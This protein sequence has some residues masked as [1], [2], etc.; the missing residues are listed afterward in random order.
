MT[1]ETFER[2]LHDL[3]NS[4]Q[5]KL[6]K[7]RRYKRNGYIVILPRRVFDSLCDRSGI[8]VKRAPES[9]GPRPGLEGRAGA[10]SKDHFEW[11]PFDGPFGRLLISPHRSS[12]PYL[13]IAW[14]RPKTSFAEWCTAHGVVFESAENRPARRLMELAYDVALFFRHHRRGKGDAR[15]GKAYTVRTPVPPL[16]PLV[17]NHETGRRFQLYIGETY[18]GSPARVHFL[19]VPDGKP[20]PPF[21]VQEPVKRI[22]HQTTRNTRNKDRL[23]ARTED[24]RSRFYLPSDWSRVPESKETEA[25]PKNLQTRIDDLVKMLAPSAD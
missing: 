12:T 25:L 11:E 18:R 1:F 13:S 2:L 4:F 23:I 10:S 3:E 5:A 24:G 20:L 14:L 22:H 16:L 9:R 7:T 17:H 19:V 21:E 15:T 8:D 6:Y